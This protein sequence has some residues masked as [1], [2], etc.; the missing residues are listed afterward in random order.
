[1]EL[2]S[3]VFIVLGAF[4]TITLIGAFAGVPMLIAASWVQWK[5]LGNP[6][7]IDAAYEALL[8]GLPA[9]QDA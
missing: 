7:T 3:L 6:K 8:A 4:L 2:G 5:A 1:M 9:A